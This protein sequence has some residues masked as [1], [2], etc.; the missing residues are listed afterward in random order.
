[1]NVLAFLVFAAG[2][3]YLLWAAAVLGRCVNRHYARRGPQ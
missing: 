2:V 1:M 3:A